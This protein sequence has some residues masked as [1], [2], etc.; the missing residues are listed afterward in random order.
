MG[1]FW[2]YESVRLRRE[3]KHSKNQLGLTKRTVYMKLPTASEIQRLVLARQLMYLS[4]PKVYAAKRLHLD[5]E[6]HVKQFKKFPLIQRVPKVY[7][8][9]RG[10]KRPLRRRRDLGKTTPTN[11]ENYCNGDLFGN[12]ESIDLCLYFLTVDDENH[13]SHN[14]DP[15][16]SPANN[17]RDNQFDFEDLSFKPI[18]PLTDSQKHEAKNSVLRVKWLKWA[19]LDMHSNSINEVVSNHRMVTVDDSTIRYNQSHFTI[20][21]ESARNALKTHDWPIL[22]QSLMGMVSTV[23]ISI[24][25]PGVFWTLGFFAIINQYKDD[26]VAVQCFLEQASELIRG[27]RTWLS[28][29]AGIWLIQKGHFNEGFELVKDWHSKSS[30]ESGFALVAKQIQNPKRDLVLCL[31]ELIIAMM[32]YSTWK[33]DY[34]MI[35]DEENLDFGNVEE[36][37]VKRAGNSALTGFEYVYKHQT[38]AKADVMSFIEPFIELVT[39]YR[40]ANRAKEIVDEVSENNVGNMFVER[41]YINFMEQH[42]PHECETEEFSQRKKKFIDQYTYDSDPSDKIKGRLKIHKLRAAKKKAG[43]NIVWLQPIPKPAFGWE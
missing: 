22:N 31:A 15:V 38:E 24:K 30:R 12:S 21:L 25:C 1:M 8:N 32:R 17:E 6:E 9:Y 39:E 10:K 18:Q 7:Y 36:E 19:Y 37:S 13:N 23:P 42:F 29:Q 14:E 34:L 2:G 33:R 43:G 20:F 28:V 3:S 27:Y 4:R 26:H 41:F 5:F 35:Q 16:E 11:K 40:S